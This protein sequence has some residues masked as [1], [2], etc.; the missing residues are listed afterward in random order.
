MGYDVFSCCSF[1][2]CN[3]SHDSGWAASGISL[4]AA[5]TIYLLSQSHMDWTHGLF[6]PHNGSKGGRVSLIVDRRRNTVPSDIVY[7][8]M[9]FGKQ[10]SC[11][12]LWTT[13]M[14][15]GN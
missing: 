7:D 10:N 12:M 6:Q 13:C 1:A 2:E 5:R 8:V 3:V 9:I 14:L 11:R 4:T 15:A